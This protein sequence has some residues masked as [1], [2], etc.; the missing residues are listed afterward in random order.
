MTGALRLTA[1]A[2]AIAVPG[3]A[4]AQV[5]IMK[6]DHQP[7]PRFYKVDGPRLSYWIPEM[8][9]FD[10]CRGSPSDARDRISTTNCRFEI[11]PKTYVW[12]R[13]RRLLDETEGVRIREEI[14]RT[15]GRYTYSN[16]EGGSYSM[17]CE[18]APEPVL[19][20]PP[21]VIM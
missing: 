9:W 12:T 5:S 8:G 18:P 17:M 13:T 10:V 20:P 6:C 16:D 3:E 4:M 2:L 15:T 21:P 7:R 1:A 19:E 14:D 11:Q